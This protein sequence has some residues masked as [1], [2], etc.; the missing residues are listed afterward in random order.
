MKTKYGI[1]ASFLIILASN[2]FAADVNWSSA[3]GEK[4]LLIG[5]PG[6]GKSTL[7]NSLVGKTVFKG[8][9]NA[10]EGLTK[11]F[12]AY[13]HNGVTFIDTP[14]L[15][16]IKYQKEAAKQIE[17]AL[18]GGG[19]YRIF[20]VMNLDSLRVRKDDIAAMNLILE[21]INV[22]ELKFNV[23]INKVS[24]REMTRLSNTKEDLAAVMLSINSMDYQTDKILFIPEDRDFEDED[25]T[26]L[27]IAKEKRDFIL[28][29]SNVTK[30][31]PEQVK[32]IQID[33]YEELKK[34]TAAQID[35]LK[36]DIASGNDRI[37]DLLDEIERGRKKPE[38]GKQENPDD[39]VPLIVN[40]IVGTFNA[41]C[42]F[43]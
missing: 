37:Q 39:L 33:K 10:G 24:K 17:M 2:L 13:L 15:N 21:A 16:D 41:I 8:G 36:Q 6:S 19:S 29:H 35:K 26:F 25:G 9:L 43:L 18:K 14:G 20:F 40:V 12:Q 7:L 28:K 32:K 1:L 5:N 42:L 11:L 27:S 34:Q 38:E 22:K 30:I 31:E 3:S 23:I 4:I